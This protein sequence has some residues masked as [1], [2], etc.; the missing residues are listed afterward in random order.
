[1]RLSS[2]STRPG[3]AG[4]LYPTGFLAA[5]PIV[6]VWW[7]ERTRLPAEVYSGLRLDYPGT[8]FNPDEQT[9]NVLRLPASDEVVANT[10]VPRGSLMNGSDNYDAYEPPFTGNGFTASST[11]IVPEFRIT[12]PTQLPAGSE[13]W[14]ITRTGTQ[15]LVGVFDGEAWV[16]VP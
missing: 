16:R 8:T 14:E 7:V 4:R 1:M 12:S 2:A 15:R 9:V 6:P 3:Y 10:E 11:G 13:M 5:P